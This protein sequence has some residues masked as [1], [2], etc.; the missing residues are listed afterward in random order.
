MDIWQLGVEA[1]VT[2][3]LLTEYSDVGIRLYKCCSI[4]RDVSV[5]AKI[6]VPYWKKQDLST[7]RTF[8]GG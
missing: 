7:Y 5:S 1:C 2:C 8:F 4:N 6:G 3:W